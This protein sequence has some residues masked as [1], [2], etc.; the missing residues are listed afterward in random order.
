MYEETYNEK[1]LSTW[2]LQS[3]PNNSGKVYIPVGGGPTFEYYTKLAHFSVGVDTDVLYIVGW[4][5]SVNP[6]GYMKY[7]F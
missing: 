6:M 7:T 5:L 3:S 1:V 2:Q 4:D